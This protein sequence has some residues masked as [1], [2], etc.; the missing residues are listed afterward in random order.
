MMA[1]IITDHCLSVRLD[2]NEEAALRGLHT[3]EVPL[4]PLATIRKVLN[5]RQLVADR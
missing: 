4:S 5:F 3:L 1:H 2:N